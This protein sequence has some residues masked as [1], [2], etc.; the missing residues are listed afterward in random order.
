MPGNFNTCRLSSHH[1]YELI[2][3]SLLNQAFPL[4][5]GHWSNAN[6]LWVLHAK[7][8]PYGRNELVVNVMFHT[9]VITKQTWESM[10]GN[11]DASLIGPMSASISL[12]I[13]RFFPDSDALPTGHR[14]WEICCTLSWLQASGSRGM[15]SV[16]LCIRTSVRQFPAS[17]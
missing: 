9:A 10:T 2:K 11:D 1:S 8:V 5:K 14:V 6:N 16:Y 15:H 17:P 7:A 12:F 4:V 13:V 3:L